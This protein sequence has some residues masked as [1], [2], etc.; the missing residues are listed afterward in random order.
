MGDATYQNE[1][2]DFVSE[3]KEHRGKLLEASNIRKI[4]QK[5]DAERSREMPNCACQGNFIEKL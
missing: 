4:N 5:Y 1:G 2:I 3:T